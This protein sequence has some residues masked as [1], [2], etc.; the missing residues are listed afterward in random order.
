MLSLG[1]FK[2]LDS[3]R[4]ITIIK[5]II[6]QGITY[7]ERDRIESNNGY[8][9]E[10]VRLLKEYLYTAEYVDRLLKA[11][12]EDSNDDISIVLLV[13]HAFIADSMI[14]EQQLKE[15]HKDVFCAN[16]KPVVVH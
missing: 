2:K 15:I 12:L 3:K 8:G 4:Q 9:V 14:A 11:L 6:A 10:L 7:S 1:K 16:S 13:S 5:D